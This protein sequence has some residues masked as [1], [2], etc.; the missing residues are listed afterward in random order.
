MALSEDPAPS[1]SIV[2]SCKPPACRCGRPTALGQRE[3]AR[4]PEPQRPP[5]ALRRIYLLQTGTDPGC[6]PG[7][8]PGEPRRPP[9][10]FLACPETLRKVLKFSEEGLNSEEFG[11]Q[12]SGVGLP[13]V[14][15]RRGDAGVSGPLPS[16]PRGA[17]PPGPRGNRAAVASAFVRA[18]QAPKGSVG[19]PASARPHATPPRPASRRLS[20]L[21]FWMAAGVISPLPRCLGAAN[22]TDMLPPSPRSASPERSR[23]RGAGGP[24]PASGQ[25]HLRARG[26]GRMLPGRVPRWPAWP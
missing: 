5:C 24:T 18:E 16:R 10:S 22:A 23:A 9:G 7:S 11:A 2:T 25:F 17:R 20:R 26:G 12:H 4:P 3:Q 14:G 21:T 15:S 19:K 6:D 8:D 13:R 1:A